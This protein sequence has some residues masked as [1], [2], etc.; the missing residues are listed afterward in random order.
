MFVVC[1]RMVV[2]LLMFFIGLAPT[3]AQDRIDFE[4]LENSR[5]WTAFR[6]PD[7]SC[8]A[9]SRPLTSKPEGANRDPVYFFVTTSIDEDLFEEISIN[10]GYPF[11]EDSEVKVSIDDRT[12]T[13]ITGDYYAWPKEVDEQKIIV[14]LMKD[15]REMVVRGTS[16]RGTDTVDTYS[17]LGITKALEAVTRSCTGG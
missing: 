3:Q 9:A 17:L 1:F 7:K 14:N 8:F 15:G 10:I 6:L 13:F 5:D 12:F 2:L 4:I 11:K 16:R